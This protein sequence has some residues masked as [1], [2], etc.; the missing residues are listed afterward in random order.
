MKPVDEQHV[1]EPDLVVLDITG[2]D[3]D[4]VRA[5]MTSR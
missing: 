5:V 4:T 1:A 3:E 2:R